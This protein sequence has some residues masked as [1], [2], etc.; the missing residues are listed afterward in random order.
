MIEDMVKSKV[1]EI[2][3]AN[4]VNSSYALQHA[5]DCAPTVAARLWQDKV[6]RFSTDILSRLCAV[7]NCQVGDLLVYVPDKKGGKK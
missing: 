6:T 3:E 4:G 5:L 1:R 2:A 7:F